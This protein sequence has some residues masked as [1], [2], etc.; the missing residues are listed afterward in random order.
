ML[1]TWIK[2][3][4]KLNNGAVCYVNDKKLGSAYTTAFDRIFKHIAS[5]SAVTMAYYYGHMANTY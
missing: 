2:V 4:K 5:V 1:P 3:L